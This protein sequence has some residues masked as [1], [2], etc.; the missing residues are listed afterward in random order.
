[1]GRDTKKL[2][3]KFFRKPVG[4]KNSRICIDCQEEIGCNHGNTKSLESDLKISHPNLY[5]EWKEREKGRTIAPRPTDPSEKK[6][7]YLDSKKSDKIGERTQ[8]IITIG[9]GVKVTKRP[10]SSSGPLAQSFAKVHY[11]YIHTD[12]FPIAN[13]NLFAHLTVCEGR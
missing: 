9:D 1:M 6:E 3:W 4:Q 2:I 10:T 13:L 5:T 11:V 8:T 7:D 12:S